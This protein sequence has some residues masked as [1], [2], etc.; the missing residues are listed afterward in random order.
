[1]FHVDLLVGDM[2][3]VEEIQDEGSLGQPRRANLPE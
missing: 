1:M 3:F 2:G